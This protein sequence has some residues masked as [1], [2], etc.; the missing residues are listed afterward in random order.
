MDCLEKTEVQSAFPIRSNASIPVEWRRKAIAA[1]F[2]KEIF[3]EASI[4]ILISVGKGEAIMNPAKD[5]RKYLWYFP[6]I[7]SSSF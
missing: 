7:F 4:A 1:N 6:R 2:L 3:I 5:A